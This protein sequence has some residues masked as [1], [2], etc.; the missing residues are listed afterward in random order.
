MVAGVLHASGLDLGGP[1]VPP[2]Q[3][4]PRGFYEH[5]PIRQKVLKPLLRSFGADA[6]GQRTLPPRILPFQPREAARLRRMIRRRLGTGWG[7]K[8][9]KII[10]V[11]QI[12]HVAFPD[13]L[14]VLVRRDSKDI[15]KSCI[16]T[17][18]MKGRTYKAGWEEWVREHEIRMSDLRKSGAEVVEVWPDPSSPGT[19]RE[20]VEACGLKWDPQTVARALEPEAW[21]TR[22]AN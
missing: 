22:K 14:W 13:A 12:F 21:H 9:A 19:F 8:D 2:S 11:W 7:Y 1:L 16:R 15:V 20:A 10:L 3:W 18:F 17:P 4:N 6:R 5:R